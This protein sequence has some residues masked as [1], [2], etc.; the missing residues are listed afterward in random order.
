MWAAIG[1]EG[2]E[3]AV[4]VVA[5]NLTFRADWRRAVEVAAAHYTRIVIAI[6][7]FCG[8][9]RTGGLSRTLRIT[10]TLKAIAV[11]ITS[12]F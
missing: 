12:G 1:F 10:E 11:G 7:L 8:I 6:A 2:A 9:A 4:L 5:H 3:L